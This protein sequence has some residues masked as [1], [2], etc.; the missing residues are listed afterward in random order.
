MRITGCLRQSVGAE[1]VSWASRTDPG[2]ALEPSDGVEPQ[3]TQRTGLL[4]DLAAG[5]L[6][7]SLLSLHWSHWA[8]TRKGQTLVC[9]LLSATLTCLLDIL[10][11]HRDYCPAPG[12]STGELK[13]RQVSRHV[14]TVCKELEN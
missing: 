12:C 10:A 13:A 8:M 9:E 3:H 1:L 11:G 7:L 6:G 4:Q 2:W 14:I 5:D